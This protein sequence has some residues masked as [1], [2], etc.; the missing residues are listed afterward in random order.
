MQPL[1]HKPEVP[2]QTTTVSPTSQ[3]PRRVSLALPSDSSPR[4][5]PVS[6][7]KFRDD[8]TIDAHKGKVR[9]IDSAPDDEAEDGDAE[10]VPSPPEKKQRRKWSP[11]ETQMLVDGCNK[12]GVGNWKAI[13]NDPTLTFANRSPVDLKDRFRTYFPEAYRSHYPNARTHVPSYA[14]SLPPSHAGPSSAIAGPSKPNRSTHP[15]GTPLFPTPSSTHAKRR[16]FTA[17]EDEALLNGFRKHGAAWATIV[18]EAPVF[19]TTGRRS[20]DLRDRF[21]NAWPDEYERAGYKARPR[22]GKRAGKEKEVANA[23]V[24]V[25]P[26][27]PM[28]ESLDEQPRGRARVGRSRTDEGLSR[29]AGTSA[30]IDGAMGPIR[31]RRRAHT[32]QGFKTLSMPGSDDEGED[33]PA[34]DCGPKSDLG[35]FSFG[36]AASDFTFKF[37]T[38]ANKVE[39]TALVG[40]MQHLVVD[41]GAAEATVDEPMPDADTADVIAPPL[42][43]KP[44]SPPVPPPHPSTPSPSK[45]QQAHFLHRR[46][47]EL[48]ALGL[49]VGAPSGPTIGRSAWGPSDWF[50]LNPRLD[51]SS[52]APQP[53]N[54]ASP[55]LANSAIHSPPL[56]SSASFPLDAAPGAGVGRDFFELTHN[57]MERYDLEQP[58][59]HGLGAQHQLHPTSSR[60]DILHQHHHHHPAL[61]ASASTPNPTFS[62]PAL[63]FHSS[64]EPDVDAFDAPHSEAGHSFSSFETPY[65]YSEAGTHDIDLLDDAE[66]E[67]GGATWGTGGGFRGFTHHSNTAGDLIFG[68]R[69]HQP[70]WGGGFGFDWGTRGR[71]LTGIAEV[72]GGKQEGENG[73]GDNDLAA[74]AEKPFTLD[75]LVDIPG[76]SDLAEGS[77]SSNE[78]GKPAMADGAGG[79]MQVEVDLEPPGTPLLR[80]TTTITTVAPVRAP[81]PRSSLPPTTVVRTVH[82]HH[83]HHHH[84]H[85]YGPPPVRS[86]SVPPPEEETMQQAQMLMSAPT[87]PLLGA[88]NAAMS[89]PS[90]FVLDSSGRGIVSTPTSSVAVNAN[91][92]AY[93]PFLDLHY[94]GGGATLDGAAEGET[95][96]WRGGEALDLARST[97]TTS[98]PPTAFGMW[99]GTSTAGVPV[100]AQAPNRPLMRSMSGSIASRS[101]NGGAIAA[102]LAARGVK[103]PT[104]SSTTR[105]GHQRGQ[106]STV[107]RPQDLHLSSAAIGAGTDGNTGS[108]S[109]KGKRKRASWDG[110]AW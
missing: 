27:G 28:D 91:G 13:I 79:G 1:E 83:H 89:P 93:L 14:A 43:P 104:T 60:I 103:D 107:V 92:H 95:A 35:A 32:S 6:V 87:T 49:S 73:D 18:K 84:H 61:S 97:T 12:H 36:S 39:E 56:S 75:D 11:E 29:A 10:K 64:F 82:V 46:Q 99:S 9:R 15:D 108:T 96:T 109:A 66:S 78:S 45:L 41:M 80:P 38:A 25:S 4:V 22:A 8:T 42:Q 7:W 24:I 105:A 106:S 85:H 48:A 98:I 101:K 72:G 30:S 74:D 76:E 86:S 16:P 68:A 94:F 53:S 57:V 21:R 102:A 54:I 69:T 50:S 70:V 81:V 44:E 47:E 20:M 71:G 110:G 33:G 17:E 3:K 55:L 52:S 62:S 26:V 90:S 31:R 67:P 77:G 63:S 100:R 40:G 65:S 34:S 58:A 37:G 23:S 51:S 2:L 19:G 59:M 5:V 88:A